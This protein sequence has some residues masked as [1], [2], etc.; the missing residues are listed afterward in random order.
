MLLD[1][2]SALIIKDHSI[3]FDKAQRLADIALEQAEK[4][5]MQP[6]EIDSGLYNRADASNYLVNEWEEEYEKPN[7]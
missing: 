6:P 2:A 4:C 7:S 1:I 5:G 3:T